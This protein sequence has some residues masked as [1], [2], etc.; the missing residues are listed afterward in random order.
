MQAIGRAALA[1]AV[2]ALEISESTLYR[3]RAV[4]RRQVV[5]VAG[6]N[7][8]YESALAGKSRRIASLRFHLSKE[9]G[10]GVSF[11]H[12]SPAQ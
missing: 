6:L 7:F 2:Q 8:A 12:G 11:A 4:H 5:V 9:G 3:W 10:N 1:A